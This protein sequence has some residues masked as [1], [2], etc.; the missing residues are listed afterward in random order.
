MNS[1][2]AKITFFKIHAKLSVLNA[3]YNNNIML[4][5]ATIVK[6]QCSNVTGLENHYLTFY[7]EKR[8]VALLPHN[9]QMR[10]MSLQIV[11][12]C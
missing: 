7:N 4:L 2:H 5:V 10:K 6:S 1:I 3:I 8:F 11:S 9:E 12:L